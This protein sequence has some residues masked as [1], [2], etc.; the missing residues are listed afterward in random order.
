MQESTLPRMCYIEELNFVM[1]NLYHFG[2]D[3]QD[4]WKSLDSFHPPGSV[5]ERIEA[6]IVS[7]VDT[8]FLLI[9]P[10][11]LTI[12]CGTQQPFIMKLQQ[13]G[14]TT[15]PD[16]IEVS[17]GMYDLA[18][19]ARQDIAGHKS[20][21]E[22]L[23]DDRLKWYRARVNKL[24]DDVQKAFPDAVKTWRATTQPEDQAQE[25]DYFNVS[26]KLK[27]VKGSSMAY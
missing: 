15:A 23:S 10:Y 11:Q 22:P 20:T 16:L 17:S 24:L 6:H 14:R 5:D 3:E 8:S 18:R 13:A 7:V 4:F 27:T 19:W 1:A 2:L 26:S 25:L 12:F 21:E 9:I